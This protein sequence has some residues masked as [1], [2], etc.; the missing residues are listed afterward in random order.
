MKK[1]V[2]EFIDVV[3]KEMVEK[4]D[5]VIKKVEDIVGKIVDMVISVELVVLYFVN[6]IGDELIFFIVIEKEN[7]F[8]EGIINVIIFIKGK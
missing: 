6:F 7:V 4:V 2:E 3:L 5:V 8:S 1:E